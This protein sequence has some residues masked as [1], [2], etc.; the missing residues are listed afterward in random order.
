MPLVSNISLPVAT[1]IEITL[2]LPVAI[3]FAITGIQPFIAA[4][5]KFIFLKVF[6][7]VKKSV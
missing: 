6:I 3:T 2:A 5:V 7:E 4:K 1:P